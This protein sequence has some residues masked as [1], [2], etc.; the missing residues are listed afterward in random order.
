MT[1]AK[2]S[3]QTGNGYKNEKLLDGEFTKTEQ[4]IAQLLNIFNKEK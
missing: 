4:I 3:G 2:Y 1:E